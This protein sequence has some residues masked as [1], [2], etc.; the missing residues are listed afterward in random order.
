VS[1]C[2]VNGVPIGKGFPVRLMGVINCSP[3]SFYPGSYVLP[4][5]VLARAEEMISHGADLVDI[6]ARSTAPRSPPLGEQAE[7]ARLEIALAELDG[8]GITVSVDTTRPV[9]LERCLSHDIHAANDISGLADPQYARIVA[10]AGLP[11][12]LM[13][14]EICPGD[15]TTLAGSFAAAEKVISRCRSAGIDNYVLDPA[16]GLWT[17]ARTTDL[18]WEI[19]RNFDHFLSYGRP[20]LAAISR[21]SFLAGTM[22]LRPEERMPASLGL[23]A[24]LIA[25]GADIVRTHDVAETAEVIRVAS[26]VVNR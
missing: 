12:F 6:G 21:K 7:L 14:S 18:D 15:A 16:I 19:C 8:S 2:L 26:R 3:E 24:L 13:A 11:A 17:T 1:R 20:L 22:H 25:R 10:D 9:V 23:T 4:G 5:A